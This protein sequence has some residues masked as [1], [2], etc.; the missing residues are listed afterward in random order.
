MLATSQ[1]IL[2]TKPLLD[3]LDKGKMLSDFVWEIY[4]KSKKK[5]PT[6]L[7]SDFRVNH[8]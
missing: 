6:N 1:S 7:F 3:K 2:C 8:I 4:L 5:D